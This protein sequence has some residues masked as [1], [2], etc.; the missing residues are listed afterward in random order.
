VADKAAGAAERLSRAAQGRGN[1]EKRKKCGELMRRRGRSRSPA[2]RRDSDDAAR[3]C[4][5]QLSVFAEPVAAESET[6]W[7]VRRRLSLSS[8]T[9]AVLGALS[10]LSCSQQLCRGTLSELE[11][12]LGEDRCKRREDGRVRLPRAPPSSSSSLRAHRDEMS[13]RSGPA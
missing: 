3:V 12:E 10:L 4:S 1:V 5:K 8:C 9:V 13:R 7:M 2:A 11:K 6:S